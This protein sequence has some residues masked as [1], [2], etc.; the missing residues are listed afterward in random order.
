MH[1]T[2]DGPL[3]KLTTHNEMCVGEKA[4]GL[5]QSTS[6][7][8]MEHVKDPISI[9]AHW[10]VFWKEDWRRERSYRE[11]VSVGK[12][13][14]YAPGV[15]RRASSMLTRTYGVFAATSSSENGAGSL[16]PWNTHTHTSRRVYHLHR[17]LCH[18]TQLPTDSDLPNTHQSSPWNFPET[19]C[20]PDLAIRLLS[21]PLPAEAWTVRIHPCIEFF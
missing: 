1:V 3:L 9:D 16:N 5:H 6:V 2:K 18:R 10:T 11:R 14:I 8:G 15:P 4:L 21:L 12:T 20:L 17:K 13:A 7:S 19:L